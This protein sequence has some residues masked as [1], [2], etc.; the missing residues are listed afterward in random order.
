VP[1]GGEHGF[2]IQWRT[3]SEIGLAFTQP[4]GASAALRKKLQALG[5]AHTQGSAP[6]VPQLALLE[7]F[8]LK[9][10]PLPFLAESFF[11]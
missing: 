10:S 8:L 6:L 3:Q 2:R 5:E 9:K 4:V 7:K 1:D 11:P